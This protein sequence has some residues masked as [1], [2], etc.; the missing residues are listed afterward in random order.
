MMNSVLDCGA[1][2]WLMIAAAA[3]TY[4]VLILGGAALAKYLFFGNRGSAPV[5]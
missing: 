2:G 5:Q 1:N 3:T 4:G